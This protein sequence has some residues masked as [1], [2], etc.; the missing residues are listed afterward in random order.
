V[1]VAGFLGVV[2]QLFGFGSDFCVQKPKEY[3]MS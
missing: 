3:D 1:K 2:V